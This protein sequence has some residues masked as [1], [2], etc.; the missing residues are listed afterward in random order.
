MDTS[1]FVLK[2]Q[3]H[4]KITDIKVKVPSITGLDTT[5]TL[6]A[7]K[8]EIPNTIDLLKKHTIL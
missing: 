4:N 8:N 6:N 3:Y 2:T 1:G 5:S 7:V